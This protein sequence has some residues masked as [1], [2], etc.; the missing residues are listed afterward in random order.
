MNPNMSWL[1]PTGGITCPICTD[2]FNPHKV[3]E[4]GGLVCLTCWS[5]ASK[6]F[7]DMVEERLKTVSSYSKIPLRWIMDIYECAPK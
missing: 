1:Y 3:Q 7:R 2:R 5:K 4:S 6:L